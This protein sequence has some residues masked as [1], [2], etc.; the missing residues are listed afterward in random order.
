MVDDW[1]L[2]MGYDEFK[3]ADE[4]DGVQHWTDARQYQRDIDG[5]AELLARG[6]LMVRVSADMLRCRHDVVVS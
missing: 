5:H 4:Y 1:R 6:W 3:V 2:D